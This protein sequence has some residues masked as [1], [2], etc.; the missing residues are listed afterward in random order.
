MSSHVVLS[1]SHLICKH[2]GPIKCNC[3]SSCQQIICTHYLDPSPDKNNFLLHLRFH[4]V[5]HQGKDVLEKRA[6]SFYENCNWKKSK[7]TVQSAHLPCNLSQKSLSLLLLWQSLNMTACSRSEIKLRLQGQLEITQLRVSWSLATF[8][9]LLMAGSKN[10]L[11][12][13]N[14]VCFLCPCHSACPT[15]WRFL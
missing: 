14:E 1:S 5:L 9:S 3:C 13:E 4:C 10:T 15:L 12:R 6:S 8:P 7:E 2:E 11:S